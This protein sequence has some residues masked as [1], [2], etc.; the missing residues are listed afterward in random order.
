MVN[1]TRSD[2]RASIAAMSRSLPRTLRAEGKSEQ[3]IYSYLLSVRL[4]SE[5]LH[6]RGHDLTVDV[7]K[8]DIRD[9]IAEQGHPKLIVDRLG[10]KHRS[11]SPATALVRLSHFSSSF[12]A[13]S[14]KRS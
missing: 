9:F 4:L 6:Q 10:R 12:A 14:R 7:A 13:A 1:N 3:T 11:G 2:R 5:F 8:D